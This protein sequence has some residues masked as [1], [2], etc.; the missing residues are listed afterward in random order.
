[1]VIEGVDVDVIV[2][3]FY[4]CFLFLLS[5]GVVVEGVEIFY[6]CCEDVGVDVKVLF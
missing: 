4:L 3:E 5:K 1:M 2:V 6:W